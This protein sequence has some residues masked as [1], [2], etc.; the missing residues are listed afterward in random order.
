MPGQPREATAAAT[1]PSPRFCENPRQR[2]ANPDGQGLTKPSSRKPLK[3]LRGSP[4]LLLSLA[5]A[6]CAVWA[7]PPAPPHTQRSV[8]PSHQE[9]H[10]AASRGAGG[11]QGAP[12]APLPRPGLPKHRKF[13]AAQFKAPQL[14]LDAW[15][16][17]PERGDL[18]GD[19]PVQGSTYRKPRYG[20]EDAGKAPVLPPCA[21][22]GHSTRHLPAHHPCYPGNTVTSPSSQPSSGFSGPE[23]ALTAASALPS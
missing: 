11:E 17:C 5:S 14:S 23:A 8:I 4:P 21:L 10:P 7:L 15:G 12:R 18:T 6:P 22:P 13:K 19:S 2:G 20:A 3:T 16:P 9:Q 1:Q